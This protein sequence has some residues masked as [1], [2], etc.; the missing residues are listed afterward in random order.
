ML[1]REAFRS[2][3][4]FGRKTRGNAPVSVRNRFFPPR[5]PRRPFRR[6]GLRTSDGRFRAGTLRP[7]RGR[8]PARRSSPRQERGDPRADVRGSFRIDLRQDRGD[9]RSLRS[10]I[11][12]FRIFFGKG[13]TW[14]EFIF[15]LRIEAIALISTKVM[16]RSPG[17]F[18]VIGADSSPRVRPGEGGSG[19]TTGR[20]PLRGNDRPIPGRRERRR[21]RRRPLRR[22]ASLPRTPA[23]TRASS[24]GGHPGPRKPRRAQISRGLLSRVGA[25]R[26]AF[27]SGR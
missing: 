23:R 19:T 4:A 13:V 9:G 22:C 14:P 18:F 17:A 24:R 15:S 16:G 10:E 7:V 11:T 21:R 3:N 26:I 8:P 12:S 6:G 5:G 1:G 25:S 2:R 20:R 27:T